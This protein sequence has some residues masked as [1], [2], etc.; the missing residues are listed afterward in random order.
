M[1]ELP[2]VEVAGPPK[3]M[4]EAFGEQCRE[5]ARDLTESRMDHL[6]GFVERHSPGRGV[7]RRSILDLVALTVPAHQ[8]FD[9]DVWAEFEGIARGA[10]LRIEELLVGN[11]YTDFRDFVLLE[12]RGTGEGG[13]DHLGE[14]SA[15][16]VPGGLAD[17]Q[18][19]VGQ[20]WDMNADAGPFLVVVHRKP[21]DAPETLGLTTT[22]CLCLIG[23]NS[24]GV[25]VGN[26]NLIPTD[27][28]V[29]VNY[30]F[31]ITHA[32]KSGSA[33]AAADAIEATPRLSGHN[34]YAADSSI[35]INMET[36]ARRSKRTVPGESAFV[37]TNHYLDDELRPFEI[38]SYDRTNTCWR[39]ET[40]SDGVGRLGEPVTMPD[41]W[42]QLSAVTQDKVGDGNATV[43]GAATLGAIVQ[44]PGRRTL[45]ICAGL[46]A[47]GNATV[48]EI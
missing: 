1:P 21:S 7:S 46:P 15:L 29:G 10:D 12:G 31:T 44:C 19:I 41:C 33:E 16:L 9:A 3:A 5:G 2:V 35:V 39:Y 11:G 36:T 48:F 14:C 42:E 4:G 24:E 25:S 38:E 17:G 6:A 45:H 40:L 27:A 8:Q 28:R 37:H 30:L 23:M 34:Y 22:G 26:T 32:L 13:G 18:P 43:R 20:T 47:P